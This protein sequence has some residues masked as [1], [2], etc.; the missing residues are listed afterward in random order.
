MDE[1]IESLQ[2]L[3]KYTTDKYPTHCE[4]DILMVP[5]VQW[6]KLTDE[7]AT[8]LDKMGWHD[9]EEYGCVASFRY[10]SC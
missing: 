3:A 4:H 8:S 2:I 6:D 9:S 10:G 7:D 1:L 5:S